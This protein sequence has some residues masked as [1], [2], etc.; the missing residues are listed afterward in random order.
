VTKASNIDKAHV[1]RKED[2][3]YDQPDQYE[4]NIHRTY[5]NRKEHHAHDRTRYRLH[6]V[7]DPIVQR[8]LNLLLSEQNIRH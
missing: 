2:R 3:P 1:D 7:I 5:R 6:E 8:A 4:W